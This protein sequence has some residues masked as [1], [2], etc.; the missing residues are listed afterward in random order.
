[1]IQPI[2]PTAAACYGVLCPV[3]NQCAR[4]ALVEGSPVETIATCESH[5]ERPL[6]LMV[7]EEQAA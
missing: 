4:Y 1:M 2:T 3:H 7:R 6:F 5:G